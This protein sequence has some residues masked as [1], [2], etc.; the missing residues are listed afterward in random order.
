M[1]GKCATCGFWLLRRETH[2]SGGEK[3]VNW[4]DPQGRGK[5]TSETLRGTLTPPT[6]GCGEHK[7]GGPIVE[8]AQK[9]G[10]AWHYSVAIPCP[11]CRAPDCGFVSPGECENKHCPGTDKCLGR[12]HTESGVDGR[13]CGTGTVQLYD[14]GFIGE[15]KRKLHPK[16]QELGKRPHLPAVCERCNEKID[17]KW[18]MCPF[19]GYDLKSEK[20]TIMVSDADAGVIPIA[21]VTQQQAG[22]P[23]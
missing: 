12:G 11:D 19:C 9:Q 17:A 4:Q 21:A 6:F 3:I 14:D 20:K 15:N 2:Y 23:R 10:E 22:E 5:C 13:C 16:E 8:V 1:T 7:D 18:R